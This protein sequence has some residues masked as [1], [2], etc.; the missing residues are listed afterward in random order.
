[1]SLDAYRFSTKKQQG[2][3]LPAALFIIVVLSLVVAAIQRLNE[4]NASAH[5]REWLS[6][7]AFYMAESAAQAAAVY[8]LN[9]SQPMVACTANMLAD[10]SPNTEGLLSCRAR[11]DCQQHTVD[12]RDYFTLTST[13]RCGSGIDQ[14]QRI[15]QV[16]LAQ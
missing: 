6:I 10:I 15:I 9:S 2:L 1:M 5:G 13:G 14:A 8:T 16:R 7:R 3:G 11:V 12:A 4:F